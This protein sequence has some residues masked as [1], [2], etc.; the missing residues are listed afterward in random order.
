MYC[1]RIKSLW[2]GLSSRYLKE[3]PNNQKNNLPTTTLFYAI[4]NEY[5][6]LLNFLIM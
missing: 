1:I 2:V 3:T 4:I 5:S 6:I